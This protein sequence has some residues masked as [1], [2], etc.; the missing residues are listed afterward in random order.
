MHFLNEPA[1]YWLW[2]L[3]DGL[4]RSCQLCISIKKRLF[5]VLNCRLIHINSVWGQNVAFS[6]AATQL[7]NVFSQTVF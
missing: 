3:N 7:K 4:F 5:G 1:S 6:C 2:L